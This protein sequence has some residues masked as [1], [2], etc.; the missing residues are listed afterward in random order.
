LRKS[1]P[2]ELIS[3]E[4][5]RVMAL[6]DIIKE[7]STNIDRLLKTNLRPRKDDTGRVRYSTLAK[8][9]RHL[10]DRWLIGRS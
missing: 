7:L 5:Y 8:M 1:K 6:D 3:V 4:G 10:Q 2:N 9:N